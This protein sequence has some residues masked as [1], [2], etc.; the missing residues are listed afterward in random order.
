M[1]TVAPHTCSGPEK[2]RDCILARRNRLIVAERIVQEKRF[3]QMHTELR[4]LPGTDALCTS[5]PGLWWLEAELQTE[6]DQP[7]VRAREYAGYLAERRAAKSGIGRG[8]LRAIE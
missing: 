5:A 1:F 7:R 8:P 6:L 3:G 2:R 4:N